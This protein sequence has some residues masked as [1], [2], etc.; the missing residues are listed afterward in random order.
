MLRAFTFKATFREQAILVS[1]TQVSENFTSSLAE[2]FACKKLCFDHQSTHQPKNN[3]R[4]KPETL[5][6]KSFQ[7]QNFQM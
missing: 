7:S 2:P 4:T 3:L 6:H 5:T 1:E